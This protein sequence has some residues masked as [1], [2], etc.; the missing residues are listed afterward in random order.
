MGLV[1]AVLVAAS[2]EGPCVAVGLVEAGQGDESA[3]ELSEQFGNADGDQAEC[4]GA[5]VAGALPGGCRN[6]AQVTIYNC[7]NDL[8]R[9][10]DER[11]YR[12]SG[13]P[14]R[15]VWVHAVDDIA[16]VNQQVFEIQL[17]LG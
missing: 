8:A 17:P 16:D 5:A 4:G 7:R 2:P 10:A 14:G 12:L 15:E 6:A 1:G 9:W 11:G 3:P 13:R